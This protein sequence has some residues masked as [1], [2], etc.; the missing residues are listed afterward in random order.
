M[1]SLKKQYYGQRVLALGL[2]RFGG[3]IAAIRYLSQQGAQV[4]VSDSAAPELLQDSQQQLQD[5]NQV[6]F[7]F[8]PQ[9]P[10]LIDGFD[11]VLVS[12]AI[13]PAHPCLEAARTAGLAIVTETELFLRACPAPVCV[14]SGTVGK[15]TTAAMIHHLL[16]N[17]QLR[18][19]LGGNIG[20]SLLPRLS[21]IMPTDK[22]VLELSSY[23][24]EYLQ[25]FPQAFPVSVLTNWIPHH[26][27]WHGSPEKYRAAKARL[28]TGQSSEH[29][30][31]LSA[32]LA[33]EDWPGNGRRILLDEMNDSE[34]PAH[35]PQHDRQN[36]RAA[37]AVLEFWK[38]DCGSQAKIF[39]TFQGLPHRLQV[40]PNSLQ[41][42]ILNDSKATSPAAVLAGLQTMNTPFWL[43]LGGAPS[44]DQTA[45]LL[46]ALNQHPHLK[47]IAWLGPAGKQN[48]SR[49]TATGNQGR[50]LQQICTTLQEAW[51]WCYA[52]SDREETILLSPG[53]PSFDEFV[54][55]VQRGE[56]W[57]RLIRETEQRNR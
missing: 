33:A 7:Q 54:H 40:I 42:Q 44:P 5:C 35:W 56:C 37:L 31:I 50:L 20:E 24:L 12:P 29:A 39:D 32:E 4:L 27:E 53:F 49:F 15:S 19:W 55:Y 28:F 22:I 17:N 45:D 41:R 52:N 46:T 48:A 43:V 38:P 23:Q 21:E 1:E 57:I 14:V 13:R 36:A 16:M 6:S 34:I 47:G 8:G 18:S 2:G 11:Q 30:A 51:E 9:T 3:Q 10:E 25:S 26:L